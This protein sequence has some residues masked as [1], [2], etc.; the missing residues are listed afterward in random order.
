MSNGNKYRIIK[1]IDTYSSGG[2]SGGVSD[3]TDTDEDN[4]FESGDD[5]THSDISD[6]I[7]DKNEL[8][9]KNDDGISATFDVNSLEEISKV[10][11]ANSVEITI[12]TVEIDD[13]TDEQKEIV[14]DRP[15]FDF[16]ILVGNKEITDFENGK[17]RISIPYELKAGENPDGLIIWY[18]ADDGTV[19][20]NE[21]AT[22]E[23]IIVE[24]D[25]NNESS[26]V[27]IYIFVGAVVLLFI[28]FIVIRRKK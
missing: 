14:S 5:I 12:E 11:G 24:T 19:E 26:N 4:A 18:V 17:V 28:A 21:P 7:Q 20:E 9:V 3:S 6:L 23:E 10:A 1:T 27:L 2:S 15:V 22:S 16:K 13:L 25:E 8:I